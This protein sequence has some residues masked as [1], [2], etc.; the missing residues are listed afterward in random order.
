MY[1]PDQLLCTSKCEGFLHHVPLLIADLSI[2][3]TDEQNIGLAK[4]VYLDFIM[5]SYRKSQMNS[6]AYPVFVSQ[7]LGGRCLP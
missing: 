5:L 4:N 2:E 7:C 6:L 1:K 3:S